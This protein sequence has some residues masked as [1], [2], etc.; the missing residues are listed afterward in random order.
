MLDRYLTDLGLT[1][2]EQKIFL[3]LTELG[4]QPAS[5]VAR[6]CS[7]DRVTTYKHLKKLSELG[8]VKIYYT[9]AIQHF[10]VEGPEAIERLLRE[11]EE[12]VK[13]LIEEFPTIAKQFAAL[14]GEGQSL[15]RVQVFEGTNGIKSCFRDVLSELKVQEIRQ[16]RLLSI[17]TFHDRLESVPLSKFMSEFRRAVDL[18][19]IDMD[20]LE[21]TGTIVPERMER[22]H[23]KDFDFSS[24]P[25]AGGATHILL[26]GAAVYLLTFKQTQIGLKIRQQ[27][28]AQVFH[29]LFD[30]AGKSV[31][32][33]Q[34]QS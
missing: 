15:P 14:S 31:V 7:L 32:R 4:L 29:F 16:V 9:H 13:S 26:A 24:L 10:G 1:D 28:M 17:N 34:E 21:A 25:A 27:E 12:H 5:V 6:H 33:S 8:L 22:R 30:L 19:G 18:E 2:K 20:I 23:M 11:R 3:A